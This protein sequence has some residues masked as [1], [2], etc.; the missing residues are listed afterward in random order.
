MLFAVHSL[1]KFKTRSTRNDSNIRKL[2]LTPTTEPKKF[3]FV[4]S[5]SAHHSTLHRPP[6][7]SEM[8]GFFRSNKSSHQVETSSDGKSEHDHAEQD[9]SA[10]LSYSQQSGLPPQEKWPNDISA[11]VLPSIRAAEIE[12]E[13]PNNST[14]PDFVNSLPMNGDIVRFNGPNFEGSIVSRMRDVHLPLHQCNHDG[15]MTNEEYFENRSRQ[16]QWTVQGRFKR[17]MRFDQ[18]MTGQEFGRPFRNMPSSTMVKR[19]LEM[20]KHKLPATFEW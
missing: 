8:L 12:Y 15:R 19:G 6:S 5:H 11:V 20:L 7:S 4:R 18:V 1:F 2:F 10:F 14:D 9:R 13:L 16:Y 17:R 3:P